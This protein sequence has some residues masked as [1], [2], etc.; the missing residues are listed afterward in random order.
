MKIVHFPSSFL[1]TIGGAEIV[2]HN[3]ALHQL[4]A[5]HE[6]AVITRWG[7]WRAVASS[8]PYKVVPLLP[9]SMMV[10]HWTRRHGCDGRWL[11]GKQLMLYQKR[12]KF[13]VWHLH[14]AYPA[15]FI[16]LPMLKRARLPSVLTCHGADIQTSPELGYGS[17]L[18]PLIEQDTIETLLHIDRAVA[19]SGSIRSE[20][21]N[22]GVL[23]ERIR[24]IPNGVD[25]ARI[26]ALQVHRRT[27][28]DAMGW[29]MD[30]VILLTV[31]RNHPKK[32]YKLIPEVIRQV[33]AVR[34]DFLWVIVGRG[35]EPIGDLASQL[36]VSDYLTVVPEIAR[37][38]TDGDHESLSLPSQGLIRIYKAADVFVFPSLLE[39]F[40]IV[41]IEAMAAGLP[42]VTTD[43]PG[44]RD[45]VEHEVTGLVSPVG[46]TGSMAQNIR[47]LLAD[48]A[49]RGGLGENGVMRSAY[50][51]WS[52]IASRY[53]QVYRE[54]VGRRN[55]ERGYDD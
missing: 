33:A 43:A 26:K 4:R 5:G 52:A 25:A 10:V 42:I 28:R 14:T 37:G 47:R 35:T 49:L 41:L 17:R 7:S 22:I 24:D 38:G 21:L 23:P 1:P 30:K 46:D 11:I 16:A 12:Y 39:S 13:D 8:V 40:G 53:S 55:S 18:D 20:Y 48:P 9:R 50:Y 34:R 19:I 44:C 54:I 36:G 15:A 31:G 29:P 6:V 45:L 32:G 3:L 51:E 2:V 27:V